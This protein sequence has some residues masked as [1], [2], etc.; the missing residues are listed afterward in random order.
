MFE[1]N[2]ILML[3]TSYFTNHTVRKFPILKLCFQ[4]HRL[5]FEGLI[6]VETILDLNDFDKL[7][8]D[9]SLKRSDLYVITPGKNSQ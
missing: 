4:V 1:L 9:K 3:Y 8:V 7:D 2:E 5:K 6:L